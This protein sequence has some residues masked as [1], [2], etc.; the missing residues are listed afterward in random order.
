M[1]FLFYQVNVQIQPD[2]RSLNAMCFRDLRVSYTTERIA[3]DSC[4]MFRLK[5]IVLILSTYS[6]SFQPKT[7]IIFS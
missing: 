3:P 1:L 2:I 4:Y 7:G 5:K 6:Q